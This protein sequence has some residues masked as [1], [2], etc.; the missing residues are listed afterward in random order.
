MQMKYIP[1]RKIFPRCRYP[2]GN[3]TIMPENRASAIPRLYYAK[4]QDPCSRS[5]RLNLLVV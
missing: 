5:P 1:M 4:I 3:Y 2:V